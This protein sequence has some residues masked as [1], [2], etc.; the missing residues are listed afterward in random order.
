MIQKRESVNQNPVCTLGLA[1][2]ANPKKN[3][4]QGS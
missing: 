3:P 4:A 2:Q 1:Q